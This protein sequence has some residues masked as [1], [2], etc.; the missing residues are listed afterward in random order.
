MNKY[1]L[2]VVNDG[3]DT[4]LL[5]VDTDHADTMASTVKW[6]LP[7]LVTGSQIMLVNNASVE[8]FD[9]EGESAS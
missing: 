9:D 7:Y 4:C 5:R 1:T 8:G 6:L 2:R 3:I